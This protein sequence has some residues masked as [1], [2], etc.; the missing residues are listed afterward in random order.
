MSYWIRFELYKHYEVINRI[1]SAKLLF[2]QPGKK[3]ERLLATHGAPKI[4]L[5]IPSVGFEEEWKKVYRKI[6]EKRFKNLGVKR[7]DLDK[8]LE[9]LNKEWDSVV[10]KHIK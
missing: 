9:V 5:E 7:K 2:V 6:Q 4:L 10:N 1:L 3:G 8:V